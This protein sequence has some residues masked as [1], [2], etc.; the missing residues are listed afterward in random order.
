M[1]IVRNEAFIKRRIR[2]TQRGTL[3]GMVLLAASFLLST[4]QQILISWL[5]LIVGYIIAMAA[6]RVGNRYVRPPRRDH[7]LDRLLKGL[8][9]KYALFHY[10][11]PAEHLLLTPSGLITILPREQRGQ[12]TVRGGRWQQRPLWQKLRLLLGDAGLGNPARELRQQIAQVTPILEELPGKGGE[13]P[14]DGL[15][16]FYSGKTTLDVEDAEFPVLLPEDLKAAV[17]K[18]AES[19]PAMPRDVHK[20]LAAKLRGEEATEVEPTEEEAEE[21]EEAPAKGSAAAA[22]ALAS[23]RKRRRKKKHQ[24]RES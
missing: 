18:V 20:A 15:I 13:I 16:V 23:G 2:F 11:L 4:R 21:Q 10:A 22:A 24:A 5:L 9:N 7:V 6:V 3:I 14:V 12:I 1:R 8:D 19:H 17:R